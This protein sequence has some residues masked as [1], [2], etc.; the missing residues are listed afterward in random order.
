MQLKTAIKK[1][2]KE[3]GKTPDSRSNIYTVGKNGGVFARMGKSHKLLFAGFVISFSSD[4]SDKIIGLFH[5][6]NIVDNSFRY[7]SLKEAIDLLK[8]NNS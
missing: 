7:C 6:R 5:I 4:D 2:E 1:I 3:L 8:P